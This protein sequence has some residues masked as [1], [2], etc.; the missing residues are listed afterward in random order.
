MGRRSPGL[1]CGAGNRTGEGMKQ[2]RSPGY[3]YP[4]GNRSHAPAVF[5]VGIVKKSKIKKRIPCP[6]RCRARDPLFCGVMQH[7]ISRTDGG[8][9]YR[10]YCSR[11]N[12][13]SSPL[14]A[15]V[16]CSLSGKLPVSGIIL[17]D[18]LVFC[19]SIEFFVVSWYDSPARTAEHEGS[20]FGL[21]SARPCI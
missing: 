7:G 3:G 12:F 9:L 15:R 13:Y 17:K 16:G 5:A 10:G 6:A 19:R 11:K 8:M 1:G 4:G 20:G 14:S 2:D 18:F 21:F